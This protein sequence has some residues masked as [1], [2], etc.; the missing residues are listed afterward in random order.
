MKI[1]KKAAFVVTII[2][3]LALIICNFAHICPEPVMES[4][5]LLRNLLAIMIAFGPLTGGFLILVGVCGLGDL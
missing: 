1:M 2:L 3:G 4:G 5:A